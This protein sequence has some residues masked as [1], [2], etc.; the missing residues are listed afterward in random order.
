MFK[1]K[2]WLKFYEPHVPEHIDYPDT[3]L[4]AVLAETAR[5]HP[6]HP[7]I[8]FKGARLSYRALNETVDRLAAA[9]QGLGVEKGDRVAIHLPSSSVPYPA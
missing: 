5:K 6:D 7:A 9:L 2:P 3:V 1:E 4:P 8:L